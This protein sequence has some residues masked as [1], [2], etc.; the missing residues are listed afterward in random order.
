MKFL[1][2]KIKK[3][4]MKFLGF[5]IMEFRIHYYEVDMIKF[6]GFIILMFLGFIIVYELTF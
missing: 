3:L 5:I 2:F 6:L 4:F 1:G